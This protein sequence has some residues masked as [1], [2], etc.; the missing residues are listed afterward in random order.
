MGTVPLIYSNGNCI[1]K[2]NATNIEN[3]RLLCKN[4][5]NFAPNILKVRI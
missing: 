4:G 2:F 3:R 5:R 1:N